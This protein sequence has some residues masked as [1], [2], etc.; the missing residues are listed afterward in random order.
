[1][2]VSKTITEETA[3][4]LISNIGQLNTSIAVFESRLLDFTKKLDHQEI[5]NNDIEARVKQIE[6]DSVGQ[7]KDINS[8]AKWQERATG[9]LITIAVSLIIEIGVGL[10]I[11]FGKGSP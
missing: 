9:A 10:I 5:I 2:T 11:M 3:R 1:M 8:Q 7:Q 4:Q 6:K